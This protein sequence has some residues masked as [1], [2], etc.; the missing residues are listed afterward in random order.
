VLDL[1]DRVPRV[2]SRS[3]LRFERCLGGRRVRARKRTLRGR[4][5][6]PT[7]FGPQRPRP[8]GVE[9]KVEAVQP[10]G[11]GLECAGTQVGALAHDS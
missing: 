10:L 3:P 5:Q 1:R 9:V 7:S 11:L 4:G 6:V 8:D 2:C